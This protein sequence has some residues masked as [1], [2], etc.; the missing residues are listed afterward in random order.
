[1]GLSLLSNANS[2]ADYA[3]ATP[4]ESRAVRKAR[5]LFVA[6][7]TTPPWKQL[8]TKTPASQQV[9]AIKRMPTII[10]KSGTASLQPAQRDV[11]TSFTTFK[12]LDRLRLLAETAGAR[13]TSP[14][15]RE[16]LQASFAKGL[17]DLQVFLGQ[18]PTD[19]VALAFATATRRADGI[20][21]KIQDPSNAKGVG[22]AAARTAALPGLTGNE[23]FCISLDKAGGGDSVIVDLAGTPQ[24]PTLDTVSDAVNAAIAAIP[25]RDGNGAVVVDAQ[26]VAVPKW[27]VRLMPD[28]STG[29]WGLAVVAPN[30]LEQMSLDQIGAG[31]TLIVATGLGASEA[32][33][34]TRLLRFDD[35]AGNLDQRSF[36]VLQATN[37]VASESAGLIAQPSKIKGVTLAAAT[38]AGSTTTR[39]IVTDASGSSYIVGTTSGDIGSN[40]ARGSSD[41]FLTKFDSEGGVVWQR[42]LGSAGTAQG[43]AVA[44]ADNGDIVVAGSVS[45]GFDG[46]TTD[47]D[48][49]V[50]RF[51]GNGDEKFVSVVRAAGNDTASAVAV[52]TDGTIYLGGRAATGGGD[53]FLARL[54]AS[55]KLVERRTIDSG[56]SESIRALAVAPDGR[57]LAVL[58]QDG[59]ATVQG[60]AAGSLTS[61]GVGLT[62]GTADARAI[63]VAADGSM[64]VAGSTL[65]ALTGRQVNAMGGGRDG[66]VTRIDGALTSAST[67]YLGDVA[68]D[69]ADSIAF[70]NG[71]IYVGGRTGGSLDGARRGIVDGFVGRIDAA[72]GAVEDVRQ[73]GQSGSIA[74][75]A[76]VAAAAGGDT[77]LAALGLHRGVLNAPG[78]DRLVAQTS[79]RAGDEFSLRVGGGPL[80]KVIIGADDTLATLAA[81]I[82]QLGGAKVQVLAVKEGA[83][84]TLRFQAAEG[85]SIELIAGS[86]GRDALAALGIAPKRLSVPPTPTANA[87]KVQPGGSFSLG[88]TEA[89]NIV[90]VKDAALALDR[91]KSAIGTTQVAFRSLYWDEGKAKLTD[92]YNGGGGAG[93]VYQQKQLVGYQAALARLQPVAGSATMFTGF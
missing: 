60:F 24:P 66:F 6:T 79:L 69:Q 76:L 36:A 88:L 89:L 35:P 17:A 38:V 86:A 10:D 1:M 8:P 11:Q 29:S 58:N 27:S 71:A 53:A 2:F 82:Q 16:L 56:G 83:G 68:D 28:K 43:A 54:D 49:I 84:R 93:S 19:K 92:G 51:D 25:K 32:V 41:L 30:A 42:S 52:A 59:R 26:G 44:L 65:A 50:G 9:S 31:D 23:Q 20:V 64:A 15:E 3:T 13:T 46:S 61:A 47:G 80:R 91:I 77:V 74:A 55:G 72:T 21:L 22:V 40:R 85:A 57:L 62:L 18:A 67:T 63:A 33:A 39:A 81:R 73:F 34:G 87:P 90:T 37:R 5:A 78:S 75:P 7:D 45:G 70:L 14:A 48:M 12:A 4:I